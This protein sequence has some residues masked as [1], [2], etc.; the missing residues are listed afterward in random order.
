MP[1][2]TKPRYNGSPTTMS[3]TSIIKSSNIML[4][5]YTDNVNSLYIPARFKSL[6]SQIREMFFSSFNFLQDCINSFK[7]FLAFELPRFIQQQQ[8]Y[9]SVDTIS[10][11]PALDKAQNNPLISASLFVSPSFS[12]FSWIKRLF[13]SSTTVNPPPL[14]EGLPN[15]VYPSEY[16]FMIYNGH[17]VAG[18]KKEKNSSLFH[19]LVSV[20]SR[21]EDSHTHL[22]SQVFDRSLRVHSCGE[23]FNRY[24]VRIEG[25]SC[26]IQS[27]VE[28]SCVEALTASTV[29]SEELQ[30]FILKKN[31]SDRGEVSRL[32]SLSEIFFGGCLY[33]L[34]FLNTTSIHPCYN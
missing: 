21:S 9:E 18:V 14:G 19:S 5:N 2:A 28:L 4:L 6:P 24:G 32:P 11:S 34:S 25:R 31:T 10:F 12:I 20:F 29:P 3:K 13:F 7:S 8:I 17:G 1:K 22:L 15:R 30:A 27:R 26:S 16:N 23:N 33:R